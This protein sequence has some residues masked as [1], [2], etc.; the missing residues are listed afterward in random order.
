MNIKKLNL[1]LFLLF[2]VLVTG[3]GTPAGQKKN[4]ETL[5][6]LYSEQFRP[7]FHFSPENGWMNDPNGLLWYDGEYHLFYQYYPDSIVW[8][9]MHWGH[10]V[11]TDL[12]HWQNL[13]IALYPDSLGYIFSG[14]AVADVNNTSG[15]GNGDKIPLVAIYALHDPVSEHSGSNT[16]ENEAMAYSLDKG[17][18]WT[19]YPGNPVLKNPGVRDFRDPKVFWHD[20]SDRWIMIL[21]VHDHINL[22]SSPD[23]KDWNFESEFGKDA[24]SHGG[25]WEC[26]DLF[27]LKEGKKDDI[28]WVMLVSINPGGPNGGSATQYFIGD[29]DGHRFVADDNT[30]KWVDY[31]PDDYAGITWT[32][33]PEND[34]RRIFIGWMSNWE[35]ATSVPAST[36]RSAMTI[37]RQLL[38]KK[39]EGKYIL[40]S[41]PVDEIEM[42]RIA[43]K[44]TGFQLDEDSKEEEILDDNF[45][46]GQCELEFDFNFMESFPDSVKIVLQNTAEEKLIVGISFLMNE[47][48]V[49]RRASGATHFSKEF[50]NIAKAPYKP[51]KTV[52]LRMLLDATSAEIFVDEG[53]LVMTTLFFP[54]EEYTNL[55][56][57]S[58]G[59]TTLTGSCKVHEFAR[60]W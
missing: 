35:Y 18:T 36:W 7:Q 17:R 12:V 57:Y 56:L 2:V 5:E 20:G 22:Y 28:K 14:S 10:A 52:K 4:K 55:R 58:K 48:Y 59:G 42:L 37:P 24:G 34:G 26:P 3:C 39:D 53:K 47:F 29:F 23:L 15:L 9:P 19:K 49:D 6:T 13:P 46:L 30:E 11:S 31:G 51:G 38:L 44:S 1:A 40:T 21:A 45:E 16:F 25:V 41:N 33:I 50:S 32:G 60:I 8:G 27:P 43:S 54:S